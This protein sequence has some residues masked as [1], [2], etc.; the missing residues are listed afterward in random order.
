MYGTTKPTDNRG[1]STSG[2]SV[3]SSSNN[4]SRPNSKPRHDPG[5]EAL[6]GS[7]DYEVLP[8]E[9]AEQ[10]Q[11]QQR[12]TR[13]LSF[14]PSG[15]DYEQIPANKKS[16]AKAKP[17][18]PPR[19]KP[20]E[21]D[22][23]AD[24]DVD[25]DGD[26]N[27]REYEDVDA[28]PRQRHAAFDENPLADEY[29]SIEGQG[30]DGKSSARTSIQQQ[31]QQQF[32]PRTRRMTLDSTSGYERLNQPDP[33]VRRASDVSGTYESR[34]ISFT[35]KRSP[36][37]GDSSNVGGDKDEGSGSDPVYSA[38]VKQKT[39]QFALA[40]P[41]RLVRKPTQF[42]K[43]PTSTMVNGMIGTMKDVD[44][45]AALAAS[46]DMGRA[47]NTANEVVY[48]DDGDVESAASS[49]RRQPT[50]YEAVDRNAKRQPTLYEALDGSSS[51]SS[52]KDN[53]NEAEYEA[54]NSRAG[55]Q[56]LYEALDGSNSNSNANNNQNNNNNNNGSEYEALDHSASARQ[57][58]L[59]ESL[60]NNNNN[61]NNNV[62]EYEA[63]DDGGTFGFDDS[64]QPASRAVSS[65][66]LPPLRKTSLYSSLAARSEELGAGDDDNNNNNT[67]NNKSNRDTVWAQPF[68][69]PFASTAAAAGGGG[70]GER[71]RSVEVDVDGEEDGGDYNNGG[72]AVYGT[73]VK[74]PPRP[75]QQLEFDADV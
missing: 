68:Y 57:A 36:G 11:Q 60:D 59:Y 33:R 13:V 10:E 54:L 21:V 20:M 56:K 35:T 52:K 27:A 9:K 29:E 66:A 31:Q 46:D 15:G 70:G 73:V 37:G 12:R 61:N 5:Y 38:P 34:P 22:V 2:N 28:R 41:P 53:G 65:S 45:A 14:V 49:L 17:A 75:P 26:T 67:N 32:D 6:P 63:V 16:E 4:S 24:V 40:L 50:L 23:D 58:K 7:G 47:G 39:T 8:G 3:N 30:D 72:R 19:K 62:S 51:S 25:G 55:G 18:V 42:D 1:S 44:L 71:K 64:D 69:S 74:A 48:G 43:S